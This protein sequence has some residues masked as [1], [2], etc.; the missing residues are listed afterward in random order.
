MTFTIF[1]CP[2]FTFWK[3]ETLELLKRFLKIIALV[4]IYRLAKLSEWWFKRY[5]QKCTLP[6]ALILIMMTQIWWIIGWLRISWEQNIILLQNKK[7]LN[8]W[9]RWHILR[10]Y[11][12][13][14]EVIFKRQKRVKT[15]V[16]AN[17]TL[18]IWTMNGMNRIEKD[19]FNEIKTN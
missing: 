8:L 12:F 7:I 15:V 18:K 1:K 17:A 9:F 16:K 13:V 2:L 5:I 14:A 6:H 10:S 4:F 3:N 19:K 11:P